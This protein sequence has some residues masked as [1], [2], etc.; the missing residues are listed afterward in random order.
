[1]FPVIISAIE[2]DDDRSFIAQLYEQYY[3]I[4]K[5]K[6]YELTRDYSITDDLVNDAIIKLIKKIPTLRS[7]DC[8]KRTTYI[9]YTIRGVAI[10][11]NRQQAAKSKKVYLGMSDDLMDSIP[12]TI[13]IDE[14]CATKEDYRE[15][16]EAI[17]QLSERDRSLLYNKYNLELS[18]TEIAKIMDIPIN[19][20]RVYLMRA[21]QRALKILTRRD[22]VNENQ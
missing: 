5:K 21:R 18:D 9:V 11:H 6:A 13:T 15:L 10:N 19:N 1:M 12:D 22:T 8:Y 14:I 2:N 17:G 20:V 16:G 3:P 4:M 7:L